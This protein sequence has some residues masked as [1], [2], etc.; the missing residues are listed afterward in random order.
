MIENLLCYHLVH[1]Y[2]I[3]INFLMFLNNH[4]CILLNYT[5]ALQYQDLWHYLLVLFI[6]LT[7]LVNRAQYLNTTPLLFLFAVIASVSDPCPATVVL[8]F[9]SM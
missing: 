2:N 8:P 7:Q 1:L 4:H 5:F 3:D 6:L 9:T